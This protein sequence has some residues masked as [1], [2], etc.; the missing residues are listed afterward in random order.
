LLSNDFVLST[1]N[2]HHASAVESEM[3]SLER[4]LKSANSL[5]NG[6]IVPRKA[7]G[8]SLLELMASLG[9]AMVAI[10]IT[11]I[12]FQPM[13]KQARVN[14]AYDTTLMAMRHYRMQA[15]S[16]RRRYMLAFTTPG[17]ITVSYLGVATPVNPPPV[18]V[19]TMT[20]PVDVE[21]AVTSGLPSTS[22]TV[23]DGFGTGATAIDFDQ[24]VGLGSQN[25]ILF[26]PDGS[27]QDTLGNLNSGVLYM[28]RRGDLQSWR[29]ISV[30][31]STGRI[32]G[33]RL[34]AGSKGGVEWT[35]Q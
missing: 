24:G 28:G 18:V 26:M 21:F 32:R 11:A 16:Q 2:W 34:V 19:E 33:W 27:S 15:I 14:T 12:S 4:S 10:S 8:F 17:T 31:G 30:F 3:N 1:R 7:Y 35:Q 9:I 13:L 29:A 23:P 5:E 20:L 6:R 22:T 25:Y